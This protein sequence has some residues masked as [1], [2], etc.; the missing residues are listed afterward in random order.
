MMETVVVRGLKVFFEPAEKV[1]LKWMANIIEIS[2]IL[3][4]KILALEQDLQQM[5]RRPPKLD[6]IKMNVN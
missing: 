6:S 4:T 5:E 3:N 2:I 1:I